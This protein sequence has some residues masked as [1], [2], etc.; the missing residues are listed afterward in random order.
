MEARRRHQKEQKEEQKSFTQSFD[1][2]YTPKD[3]WASYNAI[4]QGVDEE[5]LDDCNESM[6][7]LLVFAGLFSAV[8]TALIVETYKT[9]KI[10]PESR[11][12]HLLELILQKLGNSS[13]PD[14]TQNASEAPF[15]PPS[16]GHL[17]K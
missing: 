14:Q 13:A 12:E 16:A 7:S 17:S 5:F 11:T 1:R 6:D 2:S 10:E 15:T 4:T 9:L 8:T 3:P